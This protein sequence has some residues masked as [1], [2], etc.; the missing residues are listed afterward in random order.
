MGPPVLRKLE[1]GISAI[2]AQ[3]LKRASIISEE[4]GEE[5]GLR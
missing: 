3:P 5:P 1:A 2:N 4:G